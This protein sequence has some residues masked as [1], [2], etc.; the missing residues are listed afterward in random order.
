MPEQHGAAIL[1]PSG[2][3]FVVRGVTLVPEEQVKE[4]AQ[5]KAQAMKSLG[6]VS[7]GIGFFGSPEWVLGGVA[8][9]TFVEGLLSTV[10]KAAGISLLQSVATKVKE[11]ESSAFTFP[12]QA[13]HNS[14]IPHPQAWYAVRQREVTVAL[15]LQPTSASVIR[16]GS[17][18]AH[19]E[20]ADSVTARLINVREARVRMSNF[21][22]NETHS[23]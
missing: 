16:K 18:S 6:G 17:G 4:I 12:L 9:L 5:L 8:A 10:T 23:L 15:V 14:H 21:T 3:T 7:T 22:R 20:S 13:V 19:P 2:Q 1:L 11:L